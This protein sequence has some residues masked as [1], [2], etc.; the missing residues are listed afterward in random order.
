[1]RVRESLFDEKVTEP[2]FK[3]EV[4]EQDGDI[5]D[6]AAGNMEQQSLA[7]NCN[8]C[9]TATEGCQR[10][11][12]RLLLPTSRL[13]RVGQQGVKGGKKREGG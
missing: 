4:Q 10:N 8:Q 9:K 3:L 2:V 13:W 12:E 6:H 1:M 11:F 7:L 5:T